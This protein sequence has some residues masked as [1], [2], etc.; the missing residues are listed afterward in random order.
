M[1]MGATTVEQEGRRTGR[2]YGPVKDAR[3]IYSI[4]GLSSFFFVVHVR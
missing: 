2:V 1:A 3:C 4:T